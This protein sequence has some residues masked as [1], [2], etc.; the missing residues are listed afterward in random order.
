[1]PRSA[2]NSPKIT[3]T[4]VSVLLGP[5]CSPELRYMKL[6]VDRRHEELELSLYSFKTQ[7]VWPEHLILWT[8]RR[9]E[10][11][12][13]RPRFWFCC[14]SAVNLR[15]GLTCGPVSG[16]LGQKHLSLS[17]WISVSLT[18]GSVLFFT[19]GSSASL[20]I[21]VFP[22][23]QRLFPSFPRVMLFY[24]SVVTDAVFLF[25]TSSLR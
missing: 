19:R 3:I 25:Q 12:K 4:F 13:V 18:S 16:L 1:M 14:V 6:P 17:L 9:C 24:C 10:S 2:L 22:H 21:H 23:K 5:I 8:G 20:F 15:C 7:L 11:D